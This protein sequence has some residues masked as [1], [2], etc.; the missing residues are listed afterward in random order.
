M[1][2]KY[3]FLATSEIAGMRE[4]CSFI[5]SLRRRILYCSP[6]IGQITDK[7]LS[8]LWRSRGIFLGIRLR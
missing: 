6:E 7:I 4:D 3:V 1:L 2:Y 5:R 8:G